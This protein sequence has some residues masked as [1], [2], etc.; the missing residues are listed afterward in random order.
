[1]T[2]SLSIIHKDVKNKKMKVMLL[3]DDEVW[4]VTK[5]NFDL[6]KYLAYFRFEFMNN[7]SIFDLTK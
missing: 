6:P 1:M 7:F 2:T 4:C 5:I 3:D